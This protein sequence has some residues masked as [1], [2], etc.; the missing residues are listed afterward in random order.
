MAID[1]KKLSMDGEDFELLCRDVLESYGAEIISEPT[2]GPDQ[3]KDLVIELESKDPLGNTEKSKYLVQCKH[4]AHSNKSV[5]EAELGDFRS[6]CL[7]HDTVGYFLITST[8][9]SVTVA[10]NLNAES[11][12]GSLKTIIWDGKKL[13]GKIESSPISFQ[14]I[15][16][17]NLKENLDIKFSEMKNI[18]LGEYHL[19][20]SLFK[21]VDEEQLKGLVFEKKV[22][23]AQL[24]EKKEYS[25]YFCSVEKIDDELIQKVRIDYNLID[26]KFISNNSDSLSNIKLVDLYKEL[27]NYRDSVYQEAIWKVLSF[28]PI[29][30]IAI[31]VV[32]SSIKNLPYKPQ[33]VTIDNINLLIGKI[34]SNVGI[35]I[36]REATIAAAQ[37]NILTSRK[38]ILEQLS[39]SDSWK[40]NEVETPTL[41]ESLV[42]SLSKLD[43]ESFEFKTPMF[44]LLK[45]IKNKQVKAEVVGYFVKNKIED[46]NSI[47]NDFFND[48]KG[49]ELPP[50]NHATSFNNKQIHIFKQSYPLKIDS[51]KESYI[52]AIEKNI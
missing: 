1:Y 44:N 11:N 10:N 17:Y 3:K 47:I 22:M 24:N 39:K 41:A 18:L 15:E 21:E 9:P 16:K 31:R 27:Q 45:N 4:K 29:N 35:F 46:E 20:F 36:I 52:R 26:V 32:E 6:A 23:D 43:E 42:A 13:A 19:P 38:Y 49:V 8:I 37:L 40:L 14:I 33:K 5:F 51:L 34:P 25:G 50:T 12:K 30:P 28:C 2:R 7:L 48:N